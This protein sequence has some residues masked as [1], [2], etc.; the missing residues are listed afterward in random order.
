MWN[1]MLLHVQVR[2]GKTLSYSRKKRAK[3]ARKAALYHQQVT[4]AYNCTVK[5][6]NLKEGDLVLSTANHIKREKAY[7][8]S[9]YYLTSVKE[10]ILT[11]HVNAKWLKSY[12]C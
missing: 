4:K 6:R 12:Y 1:R 9:Y 7:R 2:G 5:P 3:A 10:C 8:S 11:K